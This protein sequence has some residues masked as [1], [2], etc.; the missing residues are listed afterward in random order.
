MGVFIGTGFG[1]VTFVLQCAGAPANVVWTHGFR[2]DGAS[3]DAA[4]AAQQWA[5]AFTA[6]GRPYAA[7]NFGNHYTFV[8][9]DATIGTST[10]PI[11]GS[12]T[13][14]TVGTLAGEEV[15]VNSAIL[16]QKSTSRGGR[17]GRGR[18]Y[19]PPAHVIEGN[20]G[21]SGTIAAVQLAAVEALYDAAYTV[22]DATAYPPYL[23]HSASEVA[24][25][26]VLS[27]TLSSKLATQR[28]RMRK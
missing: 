8:R 15:P 17:R 3:P 4:V 19:L 28:T 27:W 24:P 23:L 16:M 25:D 13:V 2:D 7:A 5:N 18:A 11:I 22:L 20:I 12:F 9:V 14:N 26:H 10:G 6:A 21:P 1:Q